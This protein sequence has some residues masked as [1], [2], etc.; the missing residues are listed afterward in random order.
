MDDI[1]NNFEEI[2]SL[3]YQ[4]SL[5]HSPYGYEVVLSGDW[6]KQ[7]YVRLPQVTAETISI[8]S[9]RALEYA[10]KYPMK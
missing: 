9:E 2:E 1:Q 10:R 8:V 4:W 3:G 6:V 5:A 7:S